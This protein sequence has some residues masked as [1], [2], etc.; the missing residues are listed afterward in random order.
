MDINGVEW[1]SFVAPESAAFSDGGPTA[2]SDG[3]ATAFSGDDPAYN[4]LD[5]ETPPPGQRLWGP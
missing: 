2:F 1:Q 3:C 5:T 4:L